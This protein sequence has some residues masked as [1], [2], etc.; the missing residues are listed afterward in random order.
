MTTLARTAISLAVLAVTTVAAVAATEHDND[1]F[2]AINGLQSFTFSETSHS[3]TSGQ[4]YSGASASVS[5]GKGQITVK[6]GRKASDSVAAWFRQQVGSGQTLVCDTK[7]TYPDQLNF[8]VEGTMS[9]GSSDGKTI[10]CDNIVVAQGNF[11]Q[12]N[13]WWMGGPGMKGAHIGP[14]GAT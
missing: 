13:N 2:F 10:E 7:G 1:A 14:S 8:A 12:F 9:I 3:I 5:S 6:A 4:P 11:G